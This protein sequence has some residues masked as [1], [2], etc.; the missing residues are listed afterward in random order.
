VAAPGQEQSG[1]SDASAIGAVWT[2]GHSTRTIED[3]VSVLQAHAIEAVADVRRH[4]GSRRLPQFNGDALERS[5]ADAG[6]AY[7][8][9]PSLGG[10][11]RPS[12][13]SPNTAWQHAAFRGYAD[14]VATEEFAEGLFEL[15]MIAGGLRIAVMCAEMLW[16]QCH[17]RL[18]A[19]VLVSLGYAVF[20]IQTTRPGEPH[21]LREPAHLVD[22][23]LSYAGDQLRLFTPPAHG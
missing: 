1:A 10:R 13:D 18:I 12:A 15:Q 6:V 17:R 16:W 3:F 19:D 8:W 5:L 9:L 4:P 14:H 11:R 23:E 22:G 20:H 2:I 7:Q 21:R